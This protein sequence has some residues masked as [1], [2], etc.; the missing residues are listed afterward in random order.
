MSKEKKFGIIVDVVSRVCERSSVVEYNLA[1]VGVAGSNP[2]VRFGD[3]HDVLIL[4][5]PLESFLLIW[6]CG[7]GGIG[8]HEGLKIL[9]HY[10]EYGFKSR[11]PH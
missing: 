4:G 9:F 8:R 2:V 5:S 3:E 11:L 6:I 7:S 1:M 10:L